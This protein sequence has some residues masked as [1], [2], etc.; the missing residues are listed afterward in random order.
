VARRCGVCGF[1][2][3]D[4]AC[5]RCGTILLRGQ[6]ICPKCGKLFSGWIAACDGCGASL[7]LDP[8]HPGDPEAVRLLASV[9]GIS[10]ER[11]K[12]LVAQGFRDLS[13]ITRL[14]LSE[15]DVRR[16]L[17]HTIARRLLLAGLAPRGPT[18]APACRCPACGAQM[19]ADSDRCATCGSA[20]STGI[21]REAV[22]QKLQ[23]VASEIVAL[24]QDEDVR[25]ELLSA[26]GGLSSEDVM[27]DEYRHQID[28]WRDR[29][30][31]VTA[32]DSLLA[33]DLEGFRERSVRLIRAQIRKRS[34]GGE[35]R[36]PLCE[37]RLPA[38]ATECENC[39]AK[40]A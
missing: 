16:G 30:F 9:P 1:E 2:T 36:C 18:P 40:F 26:L 25:R 11:A 5:P 13:D 29:G 39:G 37:A 15:S 32:L 12:I 10:E 8:E 14:A 6:A 23:T 35:Y 34:Q 31:D 7:G 38:A 19:V 27:Q 4:P 33:T 28:A 22:E 24:A 20:T 21:P 3:E 17:H